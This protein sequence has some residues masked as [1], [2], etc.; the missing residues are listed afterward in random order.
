MIRPSLTQVGPRVSSTPHVPRPAFAVAARFS[1]TA[2]GPLNPDSI[3]VISVP[4]TTKRSYV[5]CNHK[6]RVLSEAQARHFPLATRLE[7]KLTGAAL[8]VW[9]KLST[10]KASINIKITALA[11]RMLDTVAYQENC[12][13]SFPSKDAMIREINQEALSKNQPDPLVVQSHIDQLKIHHSQI[14]PIPMYHASFQTPGNIISQLEEFKTNS[15]STHLKYS[16]LCGI[17]VPISLP[18]AIVPVIPNIPGFYL[19][20]RFYCNV[21]ALSGINHLKYLLESSDGTA[22]GTR[23]L[24]FITKPEIDSVYRETNDKSD[25]Y[26]DSV[27]EEERLIISPKIIE[28]LTDKLNIPHLK[29]ELNKAWRQEKSRLKRELKVDDAVQ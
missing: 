6:P 17:G 10:S 3:F 24:D 12:L 1:S 14:K 9:T 11:K 27:Q 8:K 23:H 2:S 16:I 18:F 25:L 22:A 13:R 21:K 7:S 4:I 28:D 19:A 29:E 5:Y 15:Y 20:Y 26:I